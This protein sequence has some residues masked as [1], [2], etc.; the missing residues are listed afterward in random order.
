MNYS[1][2]ELQRLLMASKREALELRRSNERLQQ[3]LELTLK[4]MADAVE[5]MGLVLN[6]ELRCHSSK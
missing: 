4:K 3:A 2:D 5:A 6:E 1:K